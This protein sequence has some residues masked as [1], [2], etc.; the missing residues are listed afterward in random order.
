MKH[1]WRSM[2]SLVCLEKRAGARELWA[3]RLEGGQE[4]CIF[5]VGFEA[6]T[7]IPRRRARERTGQPRALLCGARQDG[8]GVQEAGA[9]SVSFCPAPHLFQCYATRIEE[10]AKNVIFFFLGADTHVCARTHTRFN[11][12]NDFVFHLSRA[13]KG[14]K[15]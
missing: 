5:Q 4:C 6:A 11:P 3:M 12:K 9:T 14:L 8:V 2:R 15:A 7:V 10:R 1:V 13:R